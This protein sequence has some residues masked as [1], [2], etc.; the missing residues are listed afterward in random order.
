MVRAE[1]D[2]VANVDGEEV[3][4]YR[5]L[6]I[7]RKLNGLSVLFPCRDSCERVVVERVSRKLGVDVPIPTEPRKDELAVVVATMLPTVSCVPVAMSAVP[8]ELD[9]MMEL[10]AK[11]EE[12]VPPLAI[13]RIP[14]TPVVRETCPPRLDRER[15]EPDIA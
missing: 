13:G 5:E 2:D 8:F 6:P 11:E 12:F 7:E 3:E 1:L 14:V 4:M 10:A 9:T 15:H